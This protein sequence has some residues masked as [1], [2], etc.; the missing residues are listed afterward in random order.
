MS[1]VHIVIFVI[2]VLLV[3][4]PIG[5]WL[6]DKSTHSEAEQ[7]SEAIERNPEIDSENQ[8][9]DEKTAMQGTVAISAEHE[10]ANPVFLGYIP[11]G[12]AFTDQEKRRLMSEGIGIVDGVEGDATENCQEY[13]ERLNRQ[14]TEYAE[15]S[16]QEVG[17]PRSGL[18]EF[19]LHPFQPWQWDHEKEAYVSVV[20]ISYSFPF[21]I[22]VVIREDL[23]ESFQSP[24]SE[25]NVVRVALIESSSGG[26]NIE[27]PDTMASGIFTVRLYRDD[28]DRAFDTSSDMPI[29]THVSGRILVA[30]PSAFGDF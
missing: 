16:Q 17:P 2:V 30:D 11:P 25:G 26:V 3:V 10:P 4:S 23:A 6:I 18:V 12:C 22:W 5:F 21:A 14:I 13:Q 27:L 1:R 7:S 9:T 8:V 20:R 28:G 24:A 15:V 19:S 29:P